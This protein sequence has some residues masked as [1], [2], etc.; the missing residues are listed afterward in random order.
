MTRLLGEL[1]ARPSVYPPGATASVAKYIADTLRAVGYA[2]EVHSRLPGV[3]NV[4]ARIGSGAPVVAFNC[5]I[6]TIA[7]GG[8]WQTEP[9]VLTSTGAGRYAGLGAVNCKGSAATH[10]WLAAEVARAGGPAQGT[11]VF[12]F[13]GDEESLGPNGTK[14]LAELGAFV[15]DQLVVAAPTSNALM[16]EERGVLWARLVTTGRAVHAGDPSAG[17]NAIGRMTR[18]LA[19]L[20]RFQ[21]S[22]LAGRHE[23]S[24]HSTLSIGTIAGGANT[25]V[26]PAHCEATLDRRLLPSS[27]T[28]TAAMAELEAVLAAAGE[29]AGSSTLELVTGTNGF[30]MSPDQP[31]VRGFADAI[32]GVTG[33]AAEIRVPIGASD[34]RFL[35][36][37]GVQIV[38]FGPGDGH[39][40]HAAN[41][42]IDERELVEACEIQYAVI[43]KSL[44]VKA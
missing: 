3:D 21:A 26:V 44:G 37:S 9:Y 42:A 19:Q 27:E 5:H 33:R 36:A 17:D 11:L 15:P 13:V 28:V 25:N 34:A 20:E 6:D 29:P 12:S 1:V 16:I 22:Q 24:H 32:S 30:R 43:R 38:I 18:L 8:E 40:G 23:G 35:A 14:L 2:V 4:V 39:Q 31:L 10:L 41:E 7:P